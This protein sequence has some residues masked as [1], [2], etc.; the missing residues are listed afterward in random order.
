MIQGAVS[1]AIAP[2]RGEAMAVYNAANTASHTRNVMPN[3][4]TRFARRKTSGSRRKENGTSRSEMK[5]NKADSDN[6]IVARAKAPQ[7][8]GI[9]PRQPNRSSRLEGEITAFPPPRAIA[10]LQR[11]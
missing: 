5:F 6:M 8:T 1:K 7:E 11:L 2:Q 3:I 9:A 4:A 10:R